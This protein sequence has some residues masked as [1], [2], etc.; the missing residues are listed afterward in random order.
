MCVKSEQQSRLRRTYH[1]GT[2]MSPR[3]A[4]HHVR[5]KGPQRGTA[6][7]A[8]GRATKEASPGRPAVGP[9]AESGV[10]KMAE[11]KGIFYGW[12]I[13]VAVFVAEAFLFSP[14][15]NCISQFTDPVSTEFGI[16]RADFTIYYTYVTL[17]GMVVSPF[18]GKI[19]RKVNFRLYMTVCVLLGIL[20]YIGF[21]F[22]TNIY[23]FY[24][25]SIL[26]GISLVAGCIVPASVLIANWFNA[27]RGL[28]LGIALAG[29]GVGGMVMSPVISAL[30]NSIGW[31]FTYLV[32]AA[33]LLVV[34]LPFMAFVVRFQ[35][36][37]KGLAPLGESVATA[38]PAADGKA[39]APVE[40]PGL[41]QREAL[42]TPS[43]WLL[44]LSVLA[45][46]IVANTMIVNL[47]P[48][49]TDC[50]IS[51]EGAALVLSV[52]NAMVIV[53]KLLV[54]KLFDNVPLKLMIVLVSAC[55]VVSFLCLM[56]AGQLWL[57]V[58]AMVLTGF[59]ATICTLAPTQVAAVIF[60]RKEFSSIFGV[61][62]MFTTLGTALCAVFANNILA[63]SGQSWQVLLVAMIVAAA[64]CAVLFLLALLTRPKFAEAK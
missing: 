21:F 41:S 26:Q 62:S 11:K 2:L 10:F 34:V 16:E 18:A 28:A 37:D 24:G 46:G 47:T 14:I 38:A 5:S 53:G 52:G 23:W 6:D 33:I 30:N 43:F 8:R 22:S 25:L 60:G 27:K 55:N 49:L 58:L 39:P 59:G 20:A 51:A 56:G 64:V 48:Y 44:C 63:A 13:M 35:P 61:V 57:A 15:V 31:R 29:S 36:S 1:G 54:G 9:V 17:A 40:I 45:A 50:G 42:R 3:D 32:L 7:R 4:P 12:W 19:M